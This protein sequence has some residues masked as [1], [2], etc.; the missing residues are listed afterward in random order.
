MQNSHLSEGRAECR[1]V[2][3]GGPFGDAARGSV[4]HASVPRYIRVQVS[5]IHS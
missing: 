3:G 4:G 2:G 5:N 1:W